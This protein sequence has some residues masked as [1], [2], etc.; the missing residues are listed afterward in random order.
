MLFP[1]GTTT[2]GD[3]VLRFHGKLFQSAQ[4][5][6]CRVQAIALRYSGDAAELAPFIGEDEFLPHLFAI[7]KLKSI[8]LQ[9]HYC[10]AMP[11]GL[12]R[13]QMA[14]ASRLQIIEQLDTARTVRYQN[15]TAL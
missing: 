5:S 10:P 7:L 6:S 15:V 3:Q 2:R 9:L 8:P 13:D 11:E 1:E 12:R 4:H 14:R